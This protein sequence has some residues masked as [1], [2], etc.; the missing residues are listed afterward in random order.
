MKDNFGLLD[1]LDRLFHGDRRSILTLN[2]FLAELQGRSYAFAV[3]A[4]L[5]L[6]MARRGAIRGD[7]FACVLLAWVTGIL[8]V[9]LAYPLGTLSLAALQGPRNAWAPELFWPRLTDPRI[10]RPLGDHITVIASEQVDEN[11]EGVTVQQV[12]QAVAQ[13]MKRI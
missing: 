11:M 5:G 8:I 7:R 3:L 9:F 6:G 1:T 12:Q 4:Q 13:R 2:E 10:W